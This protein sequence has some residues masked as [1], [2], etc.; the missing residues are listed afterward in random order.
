[1]AKR[2]EKAAPTG[3]FFWASRSPLASHE[4][5]E[6]ETALLNHYTVIQLQGEKYSH[7]PYGTYF[8]ESLSPVL[9]A[10]DAAVA[11]LKVRAESRR[12]LSLVA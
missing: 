10:F 3:K 6:L 1:M 2:L 9:E 7:L 8:K 4:R 12:L 5:A 11:A